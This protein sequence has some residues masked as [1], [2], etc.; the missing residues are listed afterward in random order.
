MIKGV[1]VLRQTDILVSQTREG[2]WV[3]V[4]VYLAIAI[5]FT[6]IAMKMSKKANNEHTNPQDKEKLVILS[7]MFSFLAVGAIAFSLLHAT[8]IKEEVPSGKYE[9]EVVIDKSVGF[10]EIHDAYEVIDSNGDVYTLRDKMPK[11][12]CSFCDSKV[13]AL[14]KYCSNCGHRQ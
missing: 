5:I 11:N 13:D 6:A 2:W 14:D 12:T 7:I 8:K 9:Y 4:L 10:R 3:P 1:E